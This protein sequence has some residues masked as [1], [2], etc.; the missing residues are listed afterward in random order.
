MFSFPIMDIVLMAGT[1]Q[2]SRVYRT[3]KREKKN[4]H[5]FKYGAVEIMKAKPQ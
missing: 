1:L 2:G 5:S 3:G 4:N